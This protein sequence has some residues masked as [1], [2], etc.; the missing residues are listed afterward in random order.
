MDG[1]NFFKDYLRDP[2]EVLSHPRFK[3]IYV[4]ELLEL[5][6]DEEAYIRI[7]ALD[8]LTM[9]L[10][11]L[12]TED[13]ENE[14]VKEVLRTANA[15]VEDIQVRLAEII[16]R[17]VH[18]LSPFN[19]HMKHKNVFINFFKFIANHKELKLR[20]LAAFNLPCFNKLY[21]DS[22]D[23][24]EIDFNEIILKYSKEDDP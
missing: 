4:A 21:K 18:Q 16:G 22:Q 6:N 2:E 1:I 9:Y 8:I 24:G 17:V 5:L 10:D 19:L 14:Y 20:R 23:D 15:D 11:Q 3:A 12:P 7:D 13:I